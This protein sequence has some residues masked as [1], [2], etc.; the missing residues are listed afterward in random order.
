MFGLL[1]SCGVLAT[2]GIWFGFKPSGY[3][4]AL[5]NL[6]CTIL[7][8]MLALGYFMPDRPFTWRSIMAIVGFLWFTWAGVQW[9]KSKATVQVNNAG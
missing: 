4:F 6:V 8:A 2:I 1:L 5:V 9:A 7:A 3:L